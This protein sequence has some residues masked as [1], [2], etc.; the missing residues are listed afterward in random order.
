MRILRHIM[1]PQLE[2]ELE[3]DSYDISK[4]HA[5]NYKESMLKDNAEG[6]KP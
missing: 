6:C 1:F 3:E 5:M 2:S 4:L